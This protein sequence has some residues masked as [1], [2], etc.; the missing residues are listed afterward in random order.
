MYN[1]NHCPVA[2]AEQSGYCNILHIGQA[3][4]VLYIGNFVTYDPHM[5]CFSYNNSVRIIC[6]TNHMCIKCSRS[7]ENHLY[8][9]MWII[10]SNIYII[11]I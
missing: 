6:I 8:T 7:D 2:L 5:H 11:L 1:Y 3:K 4:R 10:L 9:H